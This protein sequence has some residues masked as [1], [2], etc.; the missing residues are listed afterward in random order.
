MSVIQAAKYLQIDGFLDQS[1]LP[2]TVSQE[3]N[4]HLLEYVISRESR[5]VSTTTSTGEADYRNSK[6]LYEFPEISA[7]MV[8]HISAILPTV[9][10]QLDHP[11]FEVSQI[12]MQLTAHNDGNYYKMHNDNGSAAVVNRELS[13]VYYFYQEPKGFSGGE[14]RL[15]DLDVATGWYESA[16]TFVTIEPRNNSIVFFPSYYLHEVLPV[17]CPSRRFAESRFTLN[18]WICR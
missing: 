10:T 18:G 5:F 15:Y 7:W 8:H 9:F 17:A 3:C 13:Y 4:I 2:S 14:L 16:E 1:R 6:I 12:E 11:L